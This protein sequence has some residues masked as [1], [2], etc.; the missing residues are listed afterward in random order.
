MFRQHC[1]AVLFEPEFREEARGFLLVFLKDRLPRRGFGPDPSGFP[2]EGGR[3]ERAGYS[4]EGENWANWAM[5][6]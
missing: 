1:E 6:G 3:T 2:C 5:A 4:L